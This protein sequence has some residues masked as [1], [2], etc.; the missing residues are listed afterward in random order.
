MNKEDIV[1]ELSRI[2]RQLLTDQFVADLSQ[3]TYTFSNTLKVAKHFYN[4]ALDHAA[5]DCAGEF[6]DKESILNL[7]IKD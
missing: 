3:E 5:N 1:D 7:K 4:L 6:N 2:H